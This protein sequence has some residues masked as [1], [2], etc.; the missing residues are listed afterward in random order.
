MKTVSPAIGGAFLLHLSGK[1]VDEDFLHQLS[2]EIIDL[3]F[4]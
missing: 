2:Y 1:P 3:L 4:S